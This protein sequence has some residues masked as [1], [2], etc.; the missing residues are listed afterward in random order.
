MKIT[1]ERHT[2]GSI[3]AN[4]DRHPLPEGRF[5]AICAIVAGVVYAGL[6]IAAFPAWLR[7]ELRRI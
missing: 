3:T 6:V 5:K 4:I 1:I 7:L 2:D